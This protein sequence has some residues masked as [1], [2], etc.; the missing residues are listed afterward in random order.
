MILNDPE[1]MRIL[2]IGGTRFLGRVFVQQALQ[3][4]F[5]ITLFHRGV[6]GS[7]LFPQVDRILGDRRTD[8]YL[9]DGRIFDAVV[10]F[11]GYDPQEVLLSARE[12]SA[13]VEAY[14]FISTISVYEDF[15]S[16]VLQESSELQKYPKEPRF[17]SYGNLK[18]QCERVL[19]LE[20]G[21][22]RVLHLR[23]TIVVG[24]FDPTNRFEKWL[25][26]I[27]DEEDFLIPSRQD[28]P[29]QWIDV[30]DLANFT[31]SCLESQQK[32]V[33]NVCG[34]STKIS[35]ESFG[36]QIAQT[37]GA[38]P[39]YSFNALFESELPFCCPPS[40]EGIFRVDSS[41]A[42]SKGLTLSP[43]KDSIGRTSQWM[44]EK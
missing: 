7:E 15:S 19:D 21:P 1:G 9:L 22:D 3:K 11:C 23:P 37:L 30:H 5:E 34:P 14:V 40:M 25:R 6:S 33:F 39:F 26:L 24:E 41:L 2:V 27:R 28:Q 29:V 18:A 44:D 16:P 43:L 20:L 35:L 42:L 13:Q 17:R 36:S 31:I 4:G 38:S 8:L 12:L 10:D 32:G